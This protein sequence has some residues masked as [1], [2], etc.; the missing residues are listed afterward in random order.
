[1]DGM[2][3]EPTTFRL[4]FDAALF[5][6]HATSVGKVRFERD[7]VLRQRVYSPPRLS[8]SGACPR[9]VCVGD[10]HSTQTV[11]VILYDHSLVKSTTFSLE[12]EP[13]NLPGKHRSRNACAYPACRGIRVCRLGDTLR[14]GIEIQTRHGKPDRAFKL[15]RFG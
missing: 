2:G 9:I 14:P 15:H 8:S 1:M 5:I 11:L 12:N 7:S 4:S 6:H 10:R 13:K 3:F